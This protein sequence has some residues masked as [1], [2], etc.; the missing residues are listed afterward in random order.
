MGEVLHVLMKIIVDLAIYME[1]L[2]TQVYIVRNESEDICHNV[3]V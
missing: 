1:I 3:Q 2:V